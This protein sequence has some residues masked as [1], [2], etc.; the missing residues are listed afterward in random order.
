MSP[1]L[2]GWDQG[3]A[4]HRYMVL[5]HEVLSRSQLNTLSK[6]KEA[7]IIANNLVVLP[8]T[9]NICLANN[10]THISLGSRRLSQLMQD[11]H[12]GFSEHDEKYYG[13][14]VIKISE[15][16]L[17]LFVG[18]Y[19]AAPYRLD[20][21]DFHPERVLGFLPHELDYTHLRMIWRRWKQ[22]ADIKFCGQPFTPFGPQWL[23]RAM[24]KA[25]GLKGDFVIDFR[26][27][28][29][30]V[31]LLSTDASPCLDG[32]LDNDLRLKADLCG[33][34]IFDRR[35]PLYR[36]LKLRRYKK[37]GFSGF[38]SR[39]YSLFE[40][41]EDMCA[42]VDLQ[43]LTT[44]LAYKYIL[45]HKV[46]H[47]DIPDTPTAESERRQFFFG[48]AIGIPTFYVQQRT[49][50]RFMAGIL[51]LC[52]HTRHSRRYAGYIRVP[53]IEYHRALIRILR[54]DGREL[55]EMLKMDST[56]TD[57]EQRINH[58]D[59]YAVAQRLSHK[60]TGSKKRTPLRLNGREFNQAAE[61]Y[62]RNTLRTEHID[63]A[64]AI[65][66]KN[67]SELDS[68]ES[69]RNGFYNQSLMQI[70]NGGNAADFLGAV[71]QDLLSDA[72]PAA[73]CEK[74]IDLLLLVLH[75]YQK[76]NTRKPA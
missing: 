32:K 76:K 36:L 8:R 63:E 4:K 37:M 61:K 10:G 50:N 33:M 62:Y 75:A 38:E 53:G 29:Y 46:T 74:L 14:L 56:V 45:Q 25:L 9:S 11:P 17:P 48:A 19:T 64:Y 23:D 34:G 5:C 1:C 24:S 15:H 43:L 60:I 51:K 59:E 52:R 69:W 54:Q 66:R 35:M 55:I 3:E 41:A 58:P 6:L 27:I 44:L 31:S 22:K 18:T 13:D 39:H 42:S 47:A 2:S 40:K 67:M 65:F 16:F 7:G 28:D 71:R 68:M 73:A 20:F 21:N 70:L 49:A 26:L 72:L 12:S 30:L 57:L